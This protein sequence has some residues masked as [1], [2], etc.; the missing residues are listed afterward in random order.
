MFDASST[1]THQVNS[2]SSDLKIRQNQSKERQEN[3]PSCLPEDGR[4]RAFSSCGWE[5]AFRR[6]FFAYANYHGQY[7]FCN[8]NTSKNKIFSV[9]SKKISFSIQL[10]IQTNALR[11]YW[12]N[13][14]AIHDAQENS[15]SPREVYFLR[16]F[17]S[18]MMTVNFVVKPGISKRRGK[19][20]IQNHNFMKKF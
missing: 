11:N 5:F 12:E 6:S 3:W 16:K 1:A 4:A 13:V 9:T 7:P 8:V 19:Q 15:Q 17:L 20:I 14:K 18:F 10:L 2:L